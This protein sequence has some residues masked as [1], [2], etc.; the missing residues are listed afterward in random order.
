MFIKANIVSSTIIFS[1]LLFSNFSFPQYDEIKFEHF[2]TKD[3]LPDLTVNCILQDHLGYLWFGTDNG[4]VKYDGYSMTFY[5]P[6]P[7]DS[8]SLSQHKVK[9]IYEDGKNNLWIGTGWLN[10]GGL[11]RFN[12]E[13]ETF[14]HYN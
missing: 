9:V 13:V 8:N 11:N 4:L 1:F 14:T 12:R 6:Q 2:T 3:G 5:R 10:E 7:N